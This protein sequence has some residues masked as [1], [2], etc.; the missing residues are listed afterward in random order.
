MPRPSS[1]PIG[2]TLADTAKEVSRAFDEALA[3]AGG[4]RPMWLILLALKARQ[5]ETQAELARAVGVRG[6]T[7]TH[8]LD[9]LEDEGLV[10][11]HRD[12]QNRR[13]QVVGLTSD[14]DA[15]FYRL[16]R[17]AANFDEQLRAGLSDPEIDRMRATLERM[18]S[19]VSAASGD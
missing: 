10:T 5:W 17:A 3:Q 15:A 14:G 7:L 8:H 18:R 13:V 12:P 11:R 4:S 6:P 9:S 2:R 16:R 1:E 19:N